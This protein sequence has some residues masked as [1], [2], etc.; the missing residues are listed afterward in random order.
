MRYS[1]L[2][3]IC[4][5]AMLCAT[6]LS[7]GALCG[8]AEAKTS[9]SDMA[10]AKAAYSQGI[11]KFD[12]GD[13][14]GAAAS[15][16]QADKLAGDDGLYEVLAGDSLRDLKQHSSAIR[17][18]EEALEHAGKAKKGMKDKIRQKSY[19]GLAESYAE[20]GDMTKA[21]E[22]AD[23]SISEFEKDYRGHYVKGL[24]LQKTDRNQAVSEYKKSIEIDKTQYNSYVQ[25]I[26]VYK[27]LGNIQGAIDTY[28][29]AIDYRPLDEDMKMGLAQLYIKETKKEGATA[30]YYPQAVEVLKSLADVN[31]QNAYA[32]YYLSTLY[33]LMGDRESCYQ[34]LGSTN[35]L[36]AN[37]GNR[38]GR[39]IEAYVRKN[40]N[41]NG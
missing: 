38:L 22:Y 34:E 11:E 2:Q 13:M 12:S 5:S 39:E 18:Y 36:N 24:V 7:V 6:A 29:Q 8:S 21:V 28:K 37:L 26:R 3:K 1:R 32:H 19:I 41:S 15:F 35:A 16:M 27:E 10:K 4:A 31:P 25:L 20:T 30:N 17:Y 9:K 33:L 40:M 14:R 23:K